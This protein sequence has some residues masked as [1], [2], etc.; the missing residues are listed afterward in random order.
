MASRCYDL[1]A[2]HWIR[3]SFDGR[4]NSI[5]STV[6]WAWLCMDRQALRLTPQ[7]HDAFFSLLKLFWTLSSKQRDGPSDNRRW[8][9]DRNKLFECM[10]LALHRIDRREFETRREEGE[11][12]GVVKHTMSKESISRTYP[13]YNMWYTILRV[14]CNWSQPFLTSRFSVFFFI[15]G[16]EVFRKLKKEF[17]VEYIS[18][19]SVG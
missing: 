6:N 12:R 17:S 19:K 8:L 16:R 5:T 11:R 13:I 1:N 2:T 9:L 4:F 10:R 14:H 18:D 3:N 7:V 15:L